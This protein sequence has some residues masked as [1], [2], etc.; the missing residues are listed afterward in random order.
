MRKPERVVVELIS[1]IVNKLQRRIEGA[2]S[3]LFETVNVL[4]C[5]SEKG[6][7]RV[8]VI[9]KGDERPVF[10]IHDASGDRR[11]LSD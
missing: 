1:E 9:L 6:A 8:E 7:L 10:A 5:L 4:I 11:E 2:L 3:E